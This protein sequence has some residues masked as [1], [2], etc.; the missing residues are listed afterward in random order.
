MAAV[1]WSHAHPNSVYFTQIVP[2]PAKRRE[3]NA[4]LKRIAAD[5]GAFN[6]WSRE[7]MQEPVRSR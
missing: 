2:D 6:R 7:Q 3:Y 5:V 4:W 1:R